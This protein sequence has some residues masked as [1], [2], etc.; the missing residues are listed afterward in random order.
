MAEE[1]NRRAKG[2]GCLIKLADGLTTMVGW[3]DAM[4]DRVAVT[5]DL[6]N[7]AVVL[8][9]KRVGWLTKLDD[10]VTE[11]VGRVPVV[12]VLMVKRVGW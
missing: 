10:R 9:V 1:F 12:D 4:V 3:L 6:V 8:T 7:E 5:V 2:D 11:M